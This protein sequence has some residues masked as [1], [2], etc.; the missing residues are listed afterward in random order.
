MVAKSKQ[1]MHWHQYYLPLA[2]IGL[3]RS[4]LV[5]A[6]GR[7]A[8]LIELPGEDVQLQMTCEFKERQKRIRLPIA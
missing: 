2:R 1:H 8:R 3:S 4:S 5:F 6:Y 7:S